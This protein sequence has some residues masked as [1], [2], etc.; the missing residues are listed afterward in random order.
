MLDGVASKG[1]KGVTYPSP[2]LPRHNLRSGG[3]WIWPHHW[4]CTLPVKEGPCMS[5]AVISLTTV[6]PTPPPPQGFMVPIDIQTDC[7]VHVYVIIII[8]FLSFGFPFSSQVVIMPFREKRKKKNVNEALIWLS[9]SRPW[10]Q[11]LT[12]WPE[13]HPLEPHDERG[14]PLGPPQTRG[15]SDMHLSTHIHEI[16]NTCDLK[17]ATGWFSCQFKWQKWTRNFV[18][19]K[20]NNDGQLG[21]EVGD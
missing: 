20:W 11:S 15:D 16:L 4:A 14:E 5:R 2:F 17:I 8:F 12:I 21:W 3:W 7:T 13:L 18:F 19:S 1:G 9:K 6:P 10:P